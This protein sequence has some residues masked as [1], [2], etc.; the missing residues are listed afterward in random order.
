MTTV[1][2]A[3]DLF[4]LDKRVNGRAPRTILDYHRCLD[5][6][7]EW[8]EQHDI[9]LEEL[10]RNDVRRFV[11][12]D[13]RS[14]G[15]AES[16]I[17][18]HIRNLRTFLSWCHKKE[19]LT[20]DDLSQVLDAPSTSRREEHSLTP[21]EINQLLNA[22]EGDALADRDRAL[23]LL[24]LDTGVRLGEM[25]SIQRDHLQF[26]EDGKGWVRI[27]A[28]KTQ[29]W[30]FVMLG[31]RTVSALK[32]YLEQRTDEENALWIGC[33]LD[34]RLKK[35]GISK[36]IKRRG[37]QAGIDRLHPH[38][39]RHTFATHWLDASGDPERMRLILG[40]SPETLAKMM[41]TYVTSTL[42]KLKNAHERVGPVDNLPLP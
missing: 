41:E 34:K 42:E 29:Q 22:C 23:L 35:R 37:K 38:L 20:G 14:N 32:M 2:E 24:F 16:T 15:W 33:R 9:A 4:I 6:L 18:I 13:V 31:R 11:M 26:N 1:K 39:F 19:K 8:C 40:W 30:R 7:A 12:D 5:P 17:A 25:T 36:V 10:G 3:K 21:S 28:S 27:Y